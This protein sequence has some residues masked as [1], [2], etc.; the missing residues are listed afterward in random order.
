GELATASPGERLSA[1]EKEQARQLTEL[2]NRMA[3]QHVTMGAGC[4]CGM[5]GVSVT[6]EDFERDI[7][8]YL[9]AE[10]ERLD[11]PEAAA[12]ILSAGPIDDQPQAVRHLLGS[13]EA[14]RALSEAA[15]WL[16]TRLSKTIESFAR[17][18]GGSV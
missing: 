4:G 6:L 14:G 11:E 17:L 5:M 8:D 16:L 13:I 1:M 2:W 15:A 18:H 10:A 9:L 7:A 3:A 12:L